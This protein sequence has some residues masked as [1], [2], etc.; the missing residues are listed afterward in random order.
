MMIL[1]FLFG[2]GIVPQP[3][4]SPAISDTLKVSLEKFQSDHLAKF[5]AAQDAYILTH[6]IYWQG[7]E[8]PSTLPDEATKDRPPDLAKKPHDQA[9]KWDD[10]FKSL[11]ALPASWPCVQRVDVYDGPR[12]KGWTLTLAASEGSKRQERTWNFGPEKEREDKDWRE[13][14]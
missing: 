12:G 10:V 4:P 7:I 11:L 14:V 5:Q 9:E 8:T 2:F 3:Q 6:R 13:V 1:V